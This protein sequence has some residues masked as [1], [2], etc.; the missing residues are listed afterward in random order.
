MAGCFSEI[1]KP[2]NKSAL[3]KKIEQK[4]GSETSVSI[5]KDEVKVKT[6][7]TTVTLGANKDAN[8]TEIPLP[9]LPAGAKVVANIMGIGE[10][11]IN[12]SI[13]KSIDTVS[14]KYRNR[15]ATKGY[16]ELH[17]LLAEGMFSARYVK[18]DSQVSL[19]VYGHGSND[20]KT[21]LTLVARKMKP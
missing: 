17:A 7:D 2:Q 3:E 18:T 10:R 6:G 13:E 12:I 1:G 9:P 15:L 8:N 5:K 14:R 11:T 16:E 20:G 21:S 4:T 19:L